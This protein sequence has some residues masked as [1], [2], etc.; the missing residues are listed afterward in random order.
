MSIETD[1]Y[2]D[3]YP[4]DET[5]HFDEIDITGIEDPEK[6][7]TTMQRIEDYLEMNKLKKEIDDYF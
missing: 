4:E 3:Q 6:F 5:I 2:Y 7:K 1:Y